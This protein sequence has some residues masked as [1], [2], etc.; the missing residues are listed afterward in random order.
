MIEYLYSVHEVV[1]C[2]PHLASHFRVNYLIPYT[3]R[4]PIYGEE[5]SLHSTFDIAGCGNLCLKNLVDCGFLYCKAG[6]L[7]PSLHL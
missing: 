4:P 6:V 3:P 2:H 1:I 7:R 5:I